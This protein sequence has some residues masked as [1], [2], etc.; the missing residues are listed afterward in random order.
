MRAVRTVVL[1]FWAALLFNGHAFAEKQ[2][3]LVIGNSA[4]QNVN[5]LINPANDSG[6]V[7]SHRIFVN[8]MANFTLT[9]GFGSVI[10]SATNDT[11]YGRR[12]CSILGLV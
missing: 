6:K 10:G 3:A 8:D 5:R 2:V 11:V 1:A 9:T 4:Y 12:R 7:G